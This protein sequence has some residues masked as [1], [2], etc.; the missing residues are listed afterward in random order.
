LTPRSSDEEDHANAIKFARILLGQDDAY[1]A[2]KGWNQPG[3]IDRHI[4]ETMSGG[5]A[6]SD[7]TIALYLEVTVDMIVMAAASFSSLGDGEW[8]HFVFGALDTAAS[9][10]LGCSIPEDDE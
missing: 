7:E 4:H 5:H 3:A 8:E 10:L 6:R 1:I 9:V 2:V